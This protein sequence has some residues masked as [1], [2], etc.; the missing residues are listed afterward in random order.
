[1]RLPLDHKA[2]VEVDCWKLDLR[3]TASLRERTLRREVA[4]FGPNP[5]VKVQVCSV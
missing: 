2:L 1:M 5:L 4:D 3:L